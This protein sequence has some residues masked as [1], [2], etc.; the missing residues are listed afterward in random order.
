MTAV[1]K[2]ARVDVARSLLMH[3]HP[4]G[5]CLEG[6]FDGSVVYIPLRAGNE[7]MALFLIREANIDVNVTLESLATPL[8][9]A[10]SEGM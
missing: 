7:P 5:G 2:W 8:M 6:I 3:L 10:A 1:L 9:E 4:T